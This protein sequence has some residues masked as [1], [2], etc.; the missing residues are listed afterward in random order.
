MKMPDV[1]KDPPA[2]EFDAVTLRP[3]WPYD[4]ALEEA[5]IKI[6]AGELVLVTLEIGRVRS[7]LADLSQGLIAPH[8]GEVRSGGRSWGAMTPKEIM[9]HRARIGRVFDV[10]GWISN[11][12]VDENVLLAQR[13][14][15][16]VPA[17]ELRRKAEELARGFG[18]D[19]VPRQRPADSSQHEL[20]L[21]QWIRAML[22][23]MKLLVLE[24]PTRDVHPEAVKPFLDAI[25]AARRGGTAVLWVTTDGASV[26]SPLNVAPPDVTARYA[27]RGTSL[28]LQ[29][30]MK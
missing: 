18:L 24:R 29:A 28:V 15:D 26:S 2:L 12:D 6:A 11:L 8:G 30:D 4:T 1:P 25:A 17:A 3:T 22:V 27:V 21:S 23:P 14:H 19:G 9:R 16:S 13:H 10:G 20:R 5:S 7:P